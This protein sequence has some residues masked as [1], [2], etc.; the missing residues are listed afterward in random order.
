MVV[1]ARLIQVPLK[2]IAATPLRLIGVEAPAA[3]SRDELLEHAG[4]PA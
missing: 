1:G 4:L 2:T 3:Q